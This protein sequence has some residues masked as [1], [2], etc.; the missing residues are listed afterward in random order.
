V[1]VAAAA[2]AVV[3][4]GVSMLLARATHAGAASKSGSQR[5]LQAPQ[6]F[7]S[8]LNQ[9]GGFGGDFGAGSAGPQQSSAPPVAQSGGS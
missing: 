2:T 3:A 7:L 5:Q 9:D 4:F 1:K 8:A 6:S